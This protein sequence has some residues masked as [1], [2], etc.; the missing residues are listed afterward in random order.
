MCGSS[1]SC[2]GA[3][4]SD[5]SGVSSCAELLLFTGS[6]APAASDCG[7]AE[8]SAASGVTDTEPLSIPAL[9]LCATV[10]ELSLP[11]SPDCASLLYAAPDCTP[12]LSCADCIVPGPDVPALSCAYTGA[13]AVRNTATI[14]A[15]NPLVTRCLFFM[16]FFSAPCCS[17]SC[18]RLPVRKPAASQSI[19]CFIH[20]L[21]IWLLKV[22]FA[23]H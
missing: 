10:P 1:F 21:P 11:S 19:H 4:S 7:A 20:S 14:A 3:A 2:S 18:Q 16:L 9:L 8:G 12:V 6:S 23:T 15:A 13:A 5:T 17:S 22:L